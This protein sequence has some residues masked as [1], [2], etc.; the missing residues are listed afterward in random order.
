[1]DEEDYN[2]DAINYNLQ[3]N[4]QTISNVYDL[5]TLIL[6]ASMLVGENYNNSSLE[7]VEL[8]FQLFWP[9]YGIG[10]LPDDIMISY[11]YDKN[12]KEIAFSYL[13]NISWVG[14]TL[15]QTYI[16]GMLTYGSD[17]SIDMTLKYAPELSFE[18]VNLINEKNEDD[19]I[20]IEE[21]Y[22]FSATAYR[23]PAEGYFNIY[24]YFLRN[25]LNPLS[26]WGVTIAVS[27]LVRGEILSRQTRVE[28]L[29]GFAYNFFIWLHNT[30]DSWS[31]CNK[32]FIKDGS[33]WRN[34]DNI[35]V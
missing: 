27:L 29:S 12:K 6:N 3:L 30:D 4:L 28:S 25:N 32:L 22:Y 15:G 17:L 19:V 8:S 13:N 5:E 14:K 33:Q 23:I 2:Y 1:M 35:Y 16:N 9:S 31:L 20:K 7:N 18:I 26:S 11:D 21:S 10:I 24:D 34:A